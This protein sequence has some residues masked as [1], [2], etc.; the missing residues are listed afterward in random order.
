MARDVAGSG[1]SC[2]HCPRLSVSSRRK[3]VV[4]C[5]SR[6]EARSQMYYVYK[7]AGNWLLQ[8]VSIKKLHVFPKRGGAGQSMRAVG[9]FWPI[10][11]ILVAVRSDTASVLR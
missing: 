9:D 1:Q 8:V 2:S 7:Q 11:N 10:R 3:E 5:T 4:K 6:W